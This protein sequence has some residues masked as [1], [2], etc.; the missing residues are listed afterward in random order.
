MKN[1]SLIW[2]RLATALLY[3]PFL[4]VTTAGCAILIASGLTNYSYAVA[5]TADPTQ[6][7]VWGS[8][9]VVASV[10]LAFAP[11][12][13]S[14]SIS[15]RSLVG[16][17]AS[18]ILFLGCGAYSLTAA[19]GASSGVRQSAHVEAK[20]TSA[21]RTRLEAR[22]SA[23][24]A[25]LD[26]LPTARPAAELAPQIA[27][28]KATPGANGCEKVDG[29]VSKE[30]C[31]KAAALEA[32]AARAQRRD[33]LTEK[34]E[35]TEAELKAVG[36]TKLVNTDAAA[37][38]EWLSV[39]G[40]SV[41]VE[42]INRWL[43]LLPVLMLEF[44]PGM[45]FVVAGVLTPSGRDLTPSGRDLMPVES[46]RV[47]ADEPRVSTADVSGV[48]SVG[49]HSA[50]SPVPTAVVEPEATVP[51]TEDF[52]SVA[53]KSEGA[54]KTKKKTVPKAIVVDAGHADKFAALVLNA[55]GQMVGSHRSFARALDISHGHVANVLDTLVADGRLTVEASRMGTV[56]KLVD[57]KLVDLKLTRAA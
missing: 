29:K 30:V 15:K 57:L 28:L 45:A 27:S 35:A 16:L 7:L 5:K 18:V 55:G 47:Q 32:E 22:I 26:A 51:K 40:W 10:I 1:N 48:Q 4:A 8:L 11:L 33:E 2:G 54:R 17:V 42:I 6:R 34:I 43:A 37:I 19:L 24:Q 25:D 41:P 13:M 31:P 12:G 21:S 46:P 49:V 39:A 53:R 23:A 9:A 52:I 44:G 14:A 3:L 20:D 36:N 50:Q 38:S 56:V